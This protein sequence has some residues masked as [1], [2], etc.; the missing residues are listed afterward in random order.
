MSINEISN[1]LNVSG[2]TVTRI[3]NDWKKEAKKKYG[4]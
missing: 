3:F 4:K 1:D 2:N